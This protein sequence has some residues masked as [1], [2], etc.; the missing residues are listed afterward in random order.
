MKLTFAGHSV[1]IVSARPGEKIDVAKLLAYPDEFHG[2][3][4]VNHLVKFGDSFSSLIG[5]SR[6][7]LPKEAVVVLEHHF[8]EAKKLMDKINALAQ[9]LVAEPEKYDDIGFCRQYFELARA[10]YSLLAKHEAEFGFDAKS[11]PVSLERAGLVTTRLAG[12]LT[13]DAVID[14][15]VAVVTKRVHLKG[16]PETNLAVTV[17]W[18]DKHKLISINGR[19]VLLADFVNPASGASGAAFLLAAKVVKVY[20]IKVQHRSVSLT[21]QGVNLIKPALKELGVKTSFYSVGEASQLNRQYY[22][23]GNRAVADAGQVLRHFLPKFY[24]D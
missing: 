2:D 13:Q 1:E 15:E 21:R 11:I 16:E 8:D 10:G 23:V 7:V 19:E 18:R 14:N 17:K 5:Q 6:A 12:G 22:L 20:P 4:R 3:T 24:K 9:R